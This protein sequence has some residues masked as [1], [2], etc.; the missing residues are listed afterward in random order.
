[1]TIY[2]P[3]EREIEKEAEDRIMDLAKNLPRCDVEDAL[4][5]ASDQQ[6]EAIAAAQKNA[7]LLELGL[8]VWKL[9]TASV[10]DEGWRQANKW[11][12]NI[13]NDNREES[14]RNGKVA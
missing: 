2:C 9:I 14:R 7:D 3:S 12:E 8:Q 4:V 11:A 5:G 1:M 13:E 10:K 6:W